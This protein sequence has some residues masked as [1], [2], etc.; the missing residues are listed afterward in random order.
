[1]EIK[2]TG[3]I[4]ITDK[5]ASVKASSEKIVLKTG[6]VPVN[7][8]TETF[9]KS[10]EPK[11]DGTVH[12]LSSGDIKANTISSLNNPAKQAASTGGR[13][14]STLVG[15]ALGAM[16]SGVM[17]TLAD[18][19]IYELK[20]DPEVIPD[21]KN[22]KNRDI[23]PVKAENTID[24]ETIPTQKEIFETF[25]GRLLQ[26]PE[27]TLMKPE[28]VQ[29]SLRATE[30]YLEINDLPIVLEL[31]LSHVYPLFTPDL[32]VTKGYSP[33]VESVKVKDLNWH[34]V[35][36]YASSRLGPITEILDRMDKNDA[37]MLSNHSIDASVTA[38]KNVEKL[39]SINLPVSSW[40]RTI[41]LATHD[42]GHRTMIIGGFPGKVMTK[43]YQLLL[44]THM[45]DRE[46]TPQIFIAE[47][48]RQYQKNY[49]R[50]NDFFTAN[51]KDLGKIDT[52]VVGYNQ[53]F[54]ERW[55]QFSEKKVKSKGSPWS[56]EVYELPDKK[57]VA[58]L[59]S[60]ASFHG[61]ILGGNLKNLTDNHPEIKEVFLG[62][63]GGSL[64]V[65]DPYRLVY[66]KRIIG[67]SGKEIHNILSGSTEDLSHRSVIS[68]MVETPA[69]LS[70][71]AKQGTTTV[72]ME[73]GH[74][75]DALAG[76]GVKVGIGILVTDFPI[77][78]KISDDS[79]LTFQD[80]ATKYKQMSGYADSIFS[81]LESG[82][83]VYEHQIENKLGTSLDEISKKNLEWELND[84]GTLTPDEKVLFD[85]L[86]SITPNY[87]FRMTSKRLT[88][89]LEDGAI[90]STAQ[91]AR[92]KNVPVSPVT[93]EIEDKMYGALDYT[94]GAVSF[95]HGDDMYGEVNIEIKPEVWQSRSWASYRSGWRSLIGAQ[96][97]IEDGTFDYEKADPELFKKGMERFS[98][99]LVV[100]EDY[101]KS[102]AAWAI[103]QLRKDPELMKEMMKT[104]D[105]DL[106]WLINKNGL[107]FLE[108]KIKGSMNLE[109][110]ERVAV[111]ENCPEELMK[112]LNELGIPVKVL[113]KQA[114]KK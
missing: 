18:S 67:E 96:K 47:S 31:P 86:C 58:V 24:A 62:G 27:V 113:D 52:V 85:R 20:R 25:S 14:V 100:P 29:H 21:A 70:E 60:S 10:E 50:L 78:R 84:M 49:N 45:K 109:D 71:T 99:W 56:A 1:M 107:M 6:E 64:H 68:P 39:E 59:S 46:E 30:D 51:E 94:F 81:Y 11:H 102:M 112:K 72:D 23:L 97:E 5:T 40:D 66:P 89:V 48:D 44:K 22:L 13:V 65:R 9:L 38:L 101:S 92:M 74:V 75:A 35:E 12:S 54:Q 61:E 7:A 90:L 55:R 17:E 83:P 111:P 3:F 33:D 87:S 63:S 76:S 77:K 37:I 73:M 36:K 19:F 106:P 105:K 110:I 2:N 32:N 104:S 8:E 88:R 98:Q 41:H 82:K 93:P 43:H 80:S 79:N 53:A 69:F 108:G 91:V 15:G 16:L 34:N 26:I 42:D 28:S 95:G 57:R 103:R 4:K 114:P